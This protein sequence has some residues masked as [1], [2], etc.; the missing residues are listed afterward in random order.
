M[1]K[2]QTML[3]IAVFTLLLTGCGKNSSSSDSLNS[4]PSSAK[5]S[6]ISSE[7]EI[8]S[9]IISELDSEVLSSIDTP[10]SEDEEIYP[11]YYV[12][13]F[14]HLFHQSDFKA[15]GG[16]VT[17]N[18]LEWTYSAFSFLGGHTMGVQI[19]SKNNPQRNPWTLSTTLPAGVR[20]N[21]ASFHL[22]NASNGTGS[23]TLAFGNETLTDSFSSKDLVLFTFTDLNTETTTLS[24][25][26]EA[27]SGAIYF[28]NLDLSFYVNNDVSLEVTQDSIESSP[29]VPGEKGIPL[30]TYQPIAKE[31]YY[32]TI[33]M[34][35]NGNELLLSLR[36]LLTN[37]TKTSYADAK[38]MLQYS[39]ENVDNRGFLYG[40]WDGDD[41]LP[42]WDSG[43]SWQREHVW[44]ASLMQKAGEAARPEETTRNHATDLHNL[45]V[46]C[47][48]AN[49]LHGNRFVD[50]ENNATGAFF[51]NIS[52][53]LNGFHN[54]T[55]DHRGDAAR[56][57]FYMA[58]RYDHLS[59]IE[60][61]SGDGI[62]VMGRLSA[63]LRWHIE[64]PVDDFELS[65]NNRIYGYQGNR[66]PFIDYPDLVS[67]IWA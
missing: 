24:F 13:T 8:S 26:L 15:T 53:N 39:D 7:I 33:D 54:Y 43:A 56:I 14:G 2:K 50:E 47:P 28:Y 34:T 55:G 58:V 21:T 23:F 17:I 19:G 46:V 37:M 25:T 61:I 49:G 4:D 67:Q 66:N 45:R 10:T 57:Y 6:L 36:S 12:A 5:T 62:A 59:L 44:P 11:E 3:L 64:D 51:P 29:V 42:R 16:N 48:G 35:Q 60:D 18:G 9:E 38:T 27:V 52:S 30:P 63:L 20:L 31:A 65:R 22:A 1:R 32:A 41:I 40:I